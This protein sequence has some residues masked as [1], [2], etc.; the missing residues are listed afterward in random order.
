MPGNVADDVFLSLARLHLEMNQ[1]DKARDTLMAWRRQATGSQ[2]IASDKLEA[3][4]V[5]ALD[6]GLSDLA[7][8]EV[9]QAKVIDLSEPVLAILAETAFFSGHADT[10]EWLEARVGTG[11]HA[12]RPVFAAELAAER[13]Q[14]ELARRWAL[15]AAADPKR[16]TEERIRLGNVLAKVDL[17]DAAAKELRTIMSADH[18]AP[19]ALG[20]LALL[21]LNAR[22]GSRG[23]SL[24]LQSLAHGSP[25]PAA[26]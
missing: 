20:A 25:M 26:R 12:A 11:F 7:L 5:L 4:V 13:K 22:P 6:T 21:F 9:R 10:V 24:F 19:G 1:P 16:S 17:R 15:S 3:F 18:V 23:I 8:A 2:A 14:V